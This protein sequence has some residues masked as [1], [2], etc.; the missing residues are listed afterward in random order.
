MRSLFARRSTLP[1]AVLRLCGSTSKY[2][3][4]EELTRFKMLIKRLR[5]AESLCKA[6]HTAKGSIALVQQYRRISKIRKINTV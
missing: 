5:Y 1:K 4:S 3:K 2:Q 6:K